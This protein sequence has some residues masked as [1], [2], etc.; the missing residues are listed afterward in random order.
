[1]VQRRPLA[2]RS[3]SAEALVERALREA[4]QEPG[5]HVALVATDVSG[6]LVG[7]EYLMGCALRLAITNALQFAKP[8]AELK[9]AVSAGSTPNGGWSIR[10]GDNGV[11]LAPEYREKAFRM[12]WRLDPHRPGAGPG[13]GLAIVRRILRRHGGEARFLDCAAGACIELCLPGRSG[14]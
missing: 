13:A 1:L 7:D 2:L 12:F 6:D 10:I 8:D 9:V 5:A 4:E 3:C 14:Q 11:G